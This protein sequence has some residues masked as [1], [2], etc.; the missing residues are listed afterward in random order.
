MTSA[1]D[2]VV[3]E[4]PT[5]GKSPVRIDQWKYQIVA[6]AILNALPTEG[7]GVA[8]KELPGMVADA[9]DEDRKD[10]LGSISWY[11]TTVKLDLEAKGRVRRVA[12]SGPQKLLRC[13]Y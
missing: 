8:F 3:C 11:T 10:R 5:P 1:M 12:S 4:T 7:E 9:I 13:D 6:E 2:K